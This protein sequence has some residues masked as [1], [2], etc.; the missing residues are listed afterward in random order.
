MCLLNLQTQRDE[1]KETV[2]DLSIQKS[3]ICAMTKPYNRTFLAIDYGNRRIGIA[4]SDPMGIIASALTTIEVKS[5][6]DAVQKITKIIEEYQPDG[7]VFG[8]PLL[9]S[10]DKSDK[11]KEVDHFI[12][13]ISG[14]YKGKIYRVDEHASS[15]EAA[16]IIHAHGKK[17]GTDKKRVDRLAAVV[18]LNRFLEEHPA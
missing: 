17:T 10:G 8:Y 9:K 6:V 7:I 11:C 16:S 13:K 18:I 2:I 15:Q 1:N 5:Q 14:V 3:Y 4:K 12:E